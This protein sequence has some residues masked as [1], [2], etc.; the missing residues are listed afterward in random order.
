MVATRERYRV[1]LD[2][3]GDSPP[4]ELMSDFVEFMM[5]YYDASATTIPALS[6]SHPANPVTITRPSGLI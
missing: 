4:P 1:E 2:G 5:R 6:L 3:Y